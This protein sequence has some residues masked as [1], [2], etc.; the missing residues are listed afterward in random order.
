LQQTNYFA[1]VHRVA[2]IEEKRR[3]IKDREKAHLVLTNKRIKVV[4]KYLFLLL[5]RCSSKH[6]T[7]VV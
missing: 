6:G 1:L 7:Q 4:S 2:I 3:I 5:R